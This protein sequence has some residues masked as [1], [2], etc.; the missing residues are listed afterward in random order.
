M[1][2]FDSYRVFYYVAKHR[3]FTLAAQALMNSQPNVTRIIRNLETAL[4]CTLFVRSNRG[5]RL[6]PEGERLY[7]HIQLAYAHILAGEEE[8]ARN[9]SLQSGV[10]TVA[11]SEIALHCVLLPVLVQF[12]RQYPGIRIRIFNHATPQALSVL[13]NGLADLALVTGPVAAPEALTETP[14]RSFTDAAICGSAY[15]QLIGHPVRLEELQQYPIISLNLQSSTRSFYADF[16]HR[17]GC[18]LRPDIEAATADQII[19]LVKSNLG[20]GFVPEDF[21]TLQPEPGQVFTVQLVERIPKRNVCLLRRRSE[22][23]S[24][25]ART[26]YEVLCKSAQK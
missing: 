25:A 24:I 15:A 5:V 2:S 8:I 23:L 9:K 3:S 1:F 19:P 21:L 18:T 7:A 20:I 10:I 16:F 26:L 13:E 4:N 12:R 22:Q 17:H 14:L 11:C 6:T